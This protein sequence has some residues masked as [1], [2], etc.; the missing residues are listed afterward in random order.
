M[1]ITYGGKWNTGGGWHRLIFL[2]FKY[3]H[4]ERN[5]SFYSID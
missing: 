3:K 1:T 2:I 4:Y 5:R